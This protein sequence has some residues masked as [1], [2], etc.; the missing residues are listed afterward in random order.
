MAQKIKP[1]Q[2]LIAYLKQAGIKHNLLEHKTVYTAYDAAATMKRKL[3]EIAKSLLVLAGKDYY[4]ALIPA[5]HNLDFKKLAKVVAKFSGKPVKVVKIPSEK[6]MENLLKIKAGAMSAFGKFHKLPVLMDKNLAKVKKAV[7]SSG[8]FN[9]S[10][11]MAVK[12]FI[13]LENAILGDFGIKKKAKLELKKRIK[14]N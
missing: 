10:I 9:H 12:D 2:K 13:K 5:D 4:L 3:N 1:P 11:E 6:V 7:F 8:S 14:T